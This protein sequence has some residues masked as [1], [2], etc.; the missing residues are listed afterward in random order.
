MIKADLHI[1]STISDGSFTVDEILQ[2]AKLAN[3]THIAF[4]EH[5]TTKG[6]EQAISKA[7]QLG[8][9]AIPAIEVSAIDYSTGTKAHILGYGYR[10]TYHIERHCKEIL[11]RRHQNSLKQIEI[12][13]QKGYTISE[14]E[15]SR[16][17]EC[18]YKQHIMAHLVNTGQVAE[19]FGEFYKNTFKNGGE[20]DFDITYMPVQD[21]VEIIVADGGVAVLAH[22]LQQENLYL[23]E[24]LIPYGLK[25]IELFHPANPQSRYNEIRELCQK[26][27]LCG[28]GG[29]DFHGTFEATKT[30]VGEYFIDNLG[31]L[32]ND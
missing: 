29:S 30:S 31:G 14:K 2:M 32:Q 9:T 26:H 19:M 1:H 10:D 16:N 21:A 3:L 25:G 4:T 22:P 24:Q 28:T 23:V 18:I 5:D 13:K 17:D 7:A 12:L 6:Y 27:S 8:I 11:Q 20:C 15:L